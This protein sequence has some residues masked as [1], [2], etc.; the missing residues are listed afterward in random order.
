MA[1]ERHKKVTILTSLV[2]ASIAGIVSFSLLIAELAGFV[3]IVHPLFWLPI[4]AG[5]VGV[6][7]S[8]YIYFKSY[9]A[10]S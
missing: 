6:A 2:L 10:R 5:S 3:Q 4:I 8:N 9:L 7:G 1:P